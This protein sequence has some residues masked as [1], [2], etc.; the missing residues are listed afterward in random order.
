MNEGRV[1]QEGVVARGLHELLSAHEHDL[2]AR[3]GEGQ[4]PRRAATALA[5]AVVEEEGAE[6][7]RARFAGAIEDL[8][9]RTAARVLEIG[10]EALAAARS[11]ERC[12]VP[13]S[14]TPRRRTR[15]TLDAALGSATP[16][17]VARTSKTTPDNTF[18][19]F[20]GYIGDSFPEPLGQGRPASL[21]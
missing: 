1:G 9:Q 21:A 2:A 20:L 15:I 17:D 6:V 3:P 13:A 10:E 19:A 16:M 5:A 12:T 14:Y 7:L 8:L 11:S 18:A 4:R